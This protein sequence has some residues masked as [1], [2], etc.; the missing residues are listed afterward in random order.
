V[1]PAGISRPLLGKLNADIIKMLQEPAIRER[2]LGQGAE[3]SYGTPAQFHELQREEYERLGK[4]IKN[5][6]IKVQ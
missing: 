6:G 5:L 3:A 4:L 1:T 2:F